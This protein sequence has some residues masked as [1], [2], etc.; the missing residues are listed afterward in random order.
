[1]GIQLKLDAREVCGAY[2]QALRKMAALSGFDQRTVLRAEA[3][4]VLKRWAGLT[5]VSTVGQA[6][7]SARAR[8]LY[9]ITY[10]GKASANAGF[11]TINSGARGG[12]PGWMWHRT[13]NRKF[14]TAG[15]MNLSSGNYRWANIHFPN[16][17]WVEMQRA[18]EQAGQ[19]LRTM[20]P[21]ARQSVGLSRQS[22]VQIADALGIDLLRVPGQGI[23]AAGVAKA[24]AA[25]ASTGKAYRNGTG[26]SGGDDIR[27]YIDL[28]STLPYGRKIGHDR[29]LLTAINGRRRYFQESYFK[30]AFD[31]MKS[32]AAAFPNLFKITA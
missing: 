7:R 5:K 14:Q 10:K 31:S 12:T 21:R 23:S 15:V 19:A 9:G 25:L 13:A 28:I 11:M 1:M 32:A 20:V 2:S 8:A 3:G 26:Y 16:D 29:N 4:S 22:V 27:P 17:D 18:A 24:R 30:G 6:E